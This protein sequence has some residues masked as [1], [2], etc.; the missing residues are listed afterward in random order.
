MMFEGTYCSDFY[1]AVRDLLHEQV[2]I[3]LLGAAARCDAQLGV[4]RQW[5]SLLATER[6]YRSVRVEASA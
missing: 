2:R 6:Q 3:T 5:E 1:R 4:D